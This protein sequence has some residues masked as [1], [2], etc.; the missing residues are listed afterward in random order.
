[1]NSIQSHSCITSV[2]QTRFRFGLYF[3]E[4]RGFATI[5]KMKCLY[6]YTVVDPR[7]E[8]LVIILTTWLAESKTDPLVQ[9]LQ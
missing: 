5:M 2:A 4:N 1:M 3:I 6:D 9:Y 8:L 7:P